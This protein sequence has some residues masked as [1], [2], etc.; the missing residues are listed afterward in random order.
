MA[1]AA[2]REWNHLWTILEEVMESYAQVRVNG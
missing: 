1:A 2:E